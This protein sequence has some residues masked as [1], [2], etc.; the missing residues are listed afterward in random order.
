MGAFSIMNSTA[1]KSLASQYVR[2]NLIQDLLVIPG[3]SA[4]FQYVTDMMAKTVSVFRTKEAGKARGLGE[5]TNG[6]FLDSATTTTTSEYYD[7]DLDLVFT[8]PIIVPKVQDDLTGGLA[9]KG[10]LSN[11]PKTI[12][13]AINCSYFAKLIQANL[14]SAITATSAN[15]VVSYA[16]STNYVS[17]AAANT[18]AGVS[19]ALDTAIENLGKGDVSNGY[20]AFPVEESCLYGTPTFYKYLRGMSGFIVNNPIG[21]QLISSGTF[22]AFDTEYRPNTFTGYMGEILGMIAYN[23]FS[24]F[25]TTVGYLAQL[26]I[27]DGTKTAIA[28]TTALDN[29]LAIVVCGK[30]VAGGMNPGSIEVVDARGGQGWEIQPLARWGFKV[31]SSVGVQLVVNASGLTASN[32]V[33]YTG[34]DSTATQTKSLTVLL[35]GN[36]A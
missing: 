6:G 12:K 33:T 7:I 17:A 10:A 30:A 32:F 8:Q 11:L 1:V 25:N 31:F 4:D 16:F 27:A 34:A 22:N 24:L 3:K 21:Q 35:P 23:T 13:R 14:N 2:E 29:L 9:L 5:T 18:T 19:A 28:S 36:R 15:S 20:D 26:T